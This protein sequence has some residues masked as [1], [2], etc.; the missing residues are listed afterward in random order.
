MVT[1]L[2]SEVVFRRA[3]FILRFIETY[4]I[5]IIQYLA[6]YY[7]LAIYYIYPYYSSNNIQHTYV[8]RVLV[9]VFDTH[10]Q[11]CAYTY[12][13][14]TAMPRVAHCLLYVYHHPSLTYLLMLYVTSI[15]TRELLVTYSGIPQ[16][17]P[18]AIFLRRLLRRIIRR[19][20]YCVL[21]S[22][23]KA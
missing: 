13:L 18:Q 22:Q 19:V 9:G 8:S 6:Q 10:L 12:C 3:V 1:L 16:A 15:F 17:I 2:P 7:L 14:L 23:H 11:I 20:I 21:Y 4:P 5:N